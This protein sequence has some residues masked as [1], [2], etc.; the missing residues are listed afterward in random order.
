MFIKFVIPPLCWLYYVYLSTLLYFKLKG[1][2][3]YSYIWF[4]PLTSLSSKI[5]T[6]CQ[7]HYNTRHQQQQELRAIDSIDRR[8]PQQTQKKC[9]LF[10]F[11]FFVQLELPQNKTKTTTAAKLLP[12]T[13]FLES[14]LHNLINTF[15]TNDCKKRANLKKGHTEK[16]PVVL[17]ITAPW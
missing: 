9:C 6:F 1:N 15:W 16:K 12:F 4:T 14:V 5:E 10:F 7:L 3:N 2:L 11:V 17:I 13:V 8:L